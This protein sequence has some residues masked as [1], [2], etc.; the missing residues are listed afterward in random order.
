MKENFIVDLITQIADK[1][2]VMI[3]SVFFI[4]IIT[5]IGPI[6]ANFLPRSAKR[7]HVDRNTNRIVYA[8]TIES[9]H[10]ALGSTRIVVIN[11]TVIESFALSKQPNN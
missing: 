10:R 11:E 9:R 2:V 8:T 7:S 3:R 1:D 4:L 5:L 6:D